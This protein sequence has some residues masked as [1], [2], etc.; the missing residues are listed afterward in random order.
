MWFRKPHGGHC[1]ALA[2]SEFADKLN[3]QILPLPL[4]VNSRTCYLSW[5]EAAGVI[6]AIS[7]WKSC[8]SICQ[9]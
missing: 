8:W 2:G 3:L 7:G 9:R 6:K 4:K 1:P 5:H